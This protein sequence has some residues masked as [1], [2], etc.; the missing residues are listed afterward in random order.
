MVA[1]QPDLRRIG[2]KERIIGMGLT[3]FATIWG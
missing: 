3:L 1:T 2:K